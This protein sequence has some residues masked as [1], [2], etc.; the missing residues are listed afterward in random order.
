L[1]Y[2]SKQW[3]RF[4]QAAEYLNRIFKYL[5][6][7]WVKRETDEGRKHVHEVYTLAIVRWQ[8]ELFLPIHGPLLAAIL[9]MIEKGRNGDV[10]ETS[11][12]KEV[13]GSFGTTNSSIVIRIFCRLT[14]F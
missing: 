4:T 2:Y 3:N 7:H 11:L 9:G 12:L 10:I 6:R 1:K 5:N 14:R 8:Q 13:I